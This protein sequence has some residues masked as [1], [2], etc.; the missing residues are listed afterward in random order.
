MDLYAM[1]IIQNIIFKNLSASEQLKREFEKSAK[2][3]Q[4]V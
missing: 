4:K 2:N 1:D 3:R